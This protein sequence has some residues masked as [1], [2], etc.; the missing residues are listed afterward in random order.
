V[1][2][3]AKPGGCHRSVSRH[4]A[5]RPCQQLLTCLRETHAGWGAYGLARRSLVGQGWGTSI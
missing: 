3:K 1:R 2:S 5:V 4:T